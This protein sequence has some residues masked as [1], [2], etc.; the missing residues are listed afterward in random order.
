MGTAYVGMGVRFSQAELDKLAA[1]AQASCRSKAGVLK[2]LLRLAEPRDLE[3]LRIVRE[4]VDEDAQEAR[5]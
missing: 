3:M 2:A 4:I 5:A 1:L